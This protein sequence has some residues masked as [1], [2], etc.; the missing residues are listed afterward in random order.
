MKLDLWTVREFKIRNRQPITV[1][2]FKVF[3]STPTELINE[4][5]DLQA[6][7]NDLPYCLLDLKTRTDYQNYQNGYYNSKEALVFYK[8]E[9]GNIPPRI[10]QD[11]VLWCLRKGIDSDLFRSALY[12]KVIRFGWSGKYIDTWKIDKA[13]EK[14]KVLQSYFPEITI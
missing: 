7:D 5:F 14:I 6:R 13:K 12:D 3:D 8:I 11:K 9:G 2:V 4:L 10:Q 1:I